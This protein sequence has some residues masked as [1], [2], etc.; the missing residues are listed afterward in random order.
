MFLALDKMRQDDFLC[1]AT[2][3]VGPQKVLLR[4]HRTILAASSGKFKTM[5]Q[6]NSSMSVLTL[7]SFNPKSIEFFLNFI[8][9]KNV[10]LNKDN[11]PKI[12]Q[13]ANDLQCDDLLLECSRVIQ[14][15]I[16]VKNCVKV[17]T[18]SY[19]KNFGHLVESAANFIVE[20]LE[21]VAKNLDFGDLPVEMMLQLVKHP[22]A[23]IIDKNA[24]ENEKK[25]FM[26]VWD[27]IK[28]TDSQ[29]EKYMADLLEAIHL[30]QMDRE[31]FG[32]IETNAGEIPKVKEIIAKAK[33]PVEVTEIREWYLPRYRSKGTVSIKENAVDLTPDKTLATKHYSQ[34]ILIQGVPWIIYIIKTD[35]QSVLHLDSLSNVTE[36]GFRHKMIAEA[37]CKPPKKKGEKGDEI[38]VGP[39]VYFQNEAQKRPSP[40]TTINCDNAKVTITVKFETTSQ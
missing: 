9:T 10:D 2:L 32:Y 35:D 34:S 1:D 19:E 27:K 11:A 31:T 39:N 29:K 28:Y 7:D 23:V 20:N 36:M 5:F 40:P 21:K 16:D 8:Y 25:L 38:Q 15:C 30:P 18:L 17:L 26:L 24:A 3:L 6:S 13:L 4:A 22:A 37:T 33:N 14:K 12:L